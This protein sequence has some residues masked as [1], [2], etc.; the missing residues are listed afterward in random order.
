MADT[1][2][3][4]YNVPDQGDENWH[5]PLNENFAAFEVDIE[6]R[7][8]EANL[9]DYD[10][11]EGAKF[12]ATDTGV[13]YLGD[14]SSWNAAFVAAAYD[15]SAG[16]AT[17]SQTLVTSELEV[18]T[19]SGSLTGGTALTG[20]AGN[21]L[22]ID[23]NGQ[24][25]AS[26][27]GGGGGGISN[28]SGGDGID[29]ASIGDGD[30][31]S[32]AWG[33]AN[34]L[35]SDGNVTGGGGGGGGGITSLSGGEGID[36][37]SIGDG[38]TLSVAS[39]DLAG[40]GL[41]TDGNNNL[42]LAAGGVGTAELD[43]PFADLATLVGDPVVT[44]A[45]LQ[46]SGAMTFAAGGI[47]TLELGVPGTDGA[48]NQAGGNVVAGSP[49]NTV[50]NNAVGVVIG[51]GGA[52]SG[53]E[54]TVGGSYATVSGGAN[55]TASNGF[56][57]V[58]GGEANT[59]SGGATTV[60]GGNNN[61]A[62][63]GLATVGGGNR[64]TAGGTR[65]TVPGGEFGAAEGNRS[66]VWND[67]TEY[68]AIPN[69]TTDGLSS[70]TAVDGEP[71]TGSETFSA[72][73]TSGFR[74]I[75]GGSS[76]PN[77]TYVD[78]NGALGLGGTTVRTSSGDSLRF[79]SGSDRTLELGA[80]STDSGGFEAGGNVVA[81]HPNNTVNNNAK[82]VV[83]AGGG[84]ESGDENTVGEKYATVSGGKGN[85]ASGTRSTVSGGIANTASEREATVSG[86]LS[87]TAS[88][89]KATVGGGAGHTA[90]GDESTVSG[91]NSNEATELAATVG[92]GR[93][94][95]ARGSFATAG[96][97]QWNEPTGSHSTIAG[98]EYNEAYGRAA[99]IA[100]G[101]DP[102]S[103]GTGNVVYDDYGT[104]G[105]GGNNQAGT[106]DGDQTTATFA[107]VAG[108][109]NN[110]ASGE[111]ATVAGGEDN[112][113]SAAHAVAAG[114]NATAEHDGAFVVGDSTSNEIASLQVNE[115]RFQN[116][117]RARDLK[118][119]GSV[120][121][122][123]TE[124]A[125]E[126]DWRTD[127]NSNNDEWRVDRWAG[128]PIFW[129]RKMWVTASGDVEAQGAKNFVET[130]DTD[131]GEKEVVYTAS[132][133]GTAHTEESGVAELEDGRAEIDLPEHFEWVTS[134]DEPLVVQTTP[135]ASE[136]VRP[137]VT[138]RSTDRIVIEDFSEDADDYEVA[139]TVKGTREGYEDKQVVRE[140]TAR[141]P[142][143]PS[144]S[145]NPADD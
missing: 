141:D 132:E 35:D 41:G 100:G 50:N 44:G 110:E 75:T 47:R 106:D 104:V 86:G 64:N 65:S 74:F 129:E 51:G 87:S 119:Q 69:A 48:G 111:H 136:P 116:T 108:G 5:E 49:N 91:G 114:R 59:A 105:G 96:G 42:T 20:I 66:F 73:A 16:T 120:F 143:E 28:L 36:P 37:S 19:I 134:D 15:D 137:Q 67:G 93:N 103:D 25:N 117:V 125:T 17:I 32:V 3:H 4:E 92:G 46:S 83:I 24:L 145:A 78:S 130:V 128:T 26:T 79:E 112:T 97:G 95:H 43:T 94:C 99:T 6:L 11:T 98:G 52:E 8:D 63:A 133:S 23:S 10:P 62:S 68:H 122:F 27:G 31:L 121:Y 2:N 70:S 131:D 61:T 138:E 14:G 58:S 29:P 118:T 81:G 56:A 124:G 9:G 113:A 1:P 101:G 135:Y 39:G 126:A 18:G 54:N 45:D 22:S 76:S 7:D 12:L 60:S 85:T 53:N 127:Y 55:N 109:E 38:D 57:T 30:T 90:N 13:V 77:V 140:P 88:G 139:Y 107:T 102:D 71:V 89:R 33:D 40:G 80:P 123:P 34:D 21:N 82:G 142:A 84:A 115:A 144:Q 72:S